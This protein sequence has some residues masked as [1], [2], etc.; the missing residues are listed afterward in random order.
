VVGVALDG[1]KTL[2]AHQ[3][4]KEAAGTLALLAFLV[5]GVLLVVLLAKEA[6]GALALL[7]LLVT[8][9]GLGGS[10]LGAADLRMSVLLIGW[11]HLRNVTHR[12]G[13]GLGVHT[14][15]N[16]SL[17][18]ITHRLYFRKLLVEAL[19]ALGHGLV[20]LLALAYIQG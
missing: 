15:L 6:V 7:A 8:L 3:L 19:V 9:V 12:H 17:E 5:L 4:A 20:R 14:R 16:G 13:G 18:E 11:R 1:T 2:L 10:G